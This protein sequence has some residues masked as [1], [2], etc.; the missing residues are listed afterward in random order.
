M[1][2]T[3]REQ[4][5]LKRARKALRLVTQ[6]QDQAA[7]RACRD[8]VRWLGLENAN[9][10]PMAVVCGVLGET[11]QR[12]GALKE[13]EQLLAHAL[14][15][16]PDELGR[17]NPDLAR[18]ATNYAVLL[19]ETGR[20]EEAEQFYHTAIAIYEAAGPEFSDELI[21][22]VLNYALLHD[23]AEQSA[24]AAPLLER[25]VA[26]MEQSPTWPK[27]NLLATRYS[28][29]EAHYALERYD[30]A[31]AEYERVLAEL[32]AQFGPESEPVIGRLRDLIATYMRAGNLARSEHF[33]R[34]LLAIEEQR[35][36]PDSPELSPLLGD[37][38]ALCEQQ[39]RLEEST[40]LY[41]RFARI[42]PAASQALTEF[43]DRRAEAKRLYD[44]AGRHWQNEEYEAVEPL[45]LQ[46]LPMWR[47]LQGPDSEDVGTLL[48]GLASLYQLQ[49]RD[50]EAEPIFRDAIVILERFEQRAPEKLQLALRNC[51]GLLEDQGRFEESEPLFE[52]MAILSET[53]PVLHNGL[54]VLLLLAEVYRRHGKH[55]QVAGVYPR[56]FALFDPNVSRVHPI[57]VKLLDEQAEALTL[58]GREA[59]AAEV[60]RDA[61][62][63][64]AALAGTPQPKPR[65]A[66]TR[67]RKQGRSG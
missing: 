43:A 6:G 53:Y 11:L 67:A 65:R 47:E 33:I 56:I 3:V 32:E 52:R 14:W 36:G 20:A 39:G 18:M 8:V 63:V 40:A 59:E 4:E 57:T 25:A 35:L 54:D 58:A 15:I 31:S 49:Q 12:Q 64:R 7:D 16:G 62:E 55:D 29:A 41:R 30:E 50:A 5:L 17:G 46:V 13:A 10:L 9:E 42:D 38:A 60:A 24:K 27:D 28:L 21:T 34:R 26:L 2:G 23:A 45:Y 48:S 19:R 37:L 66:A 61:A 22:A 51:G 44:Q 1:T